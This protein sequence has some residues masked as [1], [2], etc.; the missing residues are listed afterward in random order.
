M[1]EEMKLETLVLAKENYSD[2]DN[3]DDDDDD[4]DE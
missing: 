4:D 2:N 3:I 1:C